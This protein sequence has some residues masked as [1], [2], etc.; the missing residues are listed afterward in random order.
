MLSYYPLPNQTA[1]AGDSDVDSDAGTPSVEWPLKHLYCVE[2]AR[3]RSGLDEYVSAIQGRGQTLTAPLKDHP[4]YGMREATVR[5]PDNN[6]IYI[7]QPL[8][9]PP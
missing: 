6:D 2:Y 3:L 8:A 5:D 7:G 4:E 9:P 1:D